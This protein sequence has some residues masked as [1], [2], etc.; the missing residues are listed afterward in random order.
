[1]FRLTL[2]ILLKRLLPDRLKVPHLIF[3]SSNTISCPSCPK[4]LLN[5]LNSATGW[6]YN[7]QQLH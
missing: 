1:M 7:K 5:S 3:E 4:R 6:T 2:V